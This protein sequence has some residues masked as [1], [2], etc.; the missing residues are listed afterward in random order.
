MS[1]PLVAV[2]ALLLLATGGASII[3]PLAGEE[4]TSA[5]LR[6]GLVMAAL[7]LAL[8]D[9]RQ[10]A[11]RWLMIGVLL[12]AVLLAIRPKLIP[13]AIVILIAMA[14]LRP[15]GTRGRTPRAR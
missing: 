4:L 14:I 12:L 8:P 3:W 1:R 6:V 13:L 9:T 11:N 5:C 2:I 15:R 10:P 7:W